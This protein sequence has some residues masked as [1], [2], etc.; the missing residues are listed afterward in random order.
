MC[1]DGEGDF[2]QKPSLKLTFLTRNLLKIFA[3]R[4]R[5]TGPGLAGQEQ[6]FVGQT[7]HPRGQQVRSGQVCLPGTVASEFCCRM[8]VNQ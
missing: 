2:S 5:G 1:V 7:L 3:I 8:T 6:L 4:T